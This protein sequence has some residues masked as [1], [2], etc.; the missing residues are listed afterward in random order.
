MLKETETE[1]TKGVCHVFV[2]VGILIG[3]GRGPGPPLVTV[4]RIIQGC[5]MLERLI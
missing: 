5:S 2:I 4:L 1:E 3:G